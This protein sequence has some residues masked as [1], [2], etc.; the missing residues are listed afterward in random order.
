MKK[1]PKRVARHKNS[2]K[3]TAARTSIPVTPPAPGSRPDKDLYTRDRDQILRDIVTP[4]KPDA[5]RELDI[6]GPCET[7]AAALRGY[8]T[9]DYQHA[10]EIQNLRDQIVNYLTDGSRKRPFNIV[11][12]ADSGSG[13][14][15]FIDCLGKSLERRNVRSVTFN[16]ATLEGLDD[17]T[18]PMDAIRN[19]KVK[20]KLPLLFLDEFDSKESNY[21]ILLPLLWDGELRVAHRNLRLGKVVIILAGSGEKIAE[22]MSEARDMKARTRSWPNRLAD[23]LSRI[24]GPE[25]CIP[26]LDVNDASHDRRA[27]KACIAAS[28]LRKRFPRLEMAP[29][30]LLSFISRTRFRYGVRS[31]AYLIDTI[32]AASLE[33]DRLILERLGLPLA[34]WRRLAT[35][36]I[37]YHLIGHDGAVGIAESWNQLAKYTID[38]RLCARQTEGFLPE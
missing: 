38:V 24:N 5:Q 14:S 11:M 37:A 16:M 17:F 26:D 10:R 21:A 6:T 7:G 9:L 27:D 1:K 33:S 34:D 25:F 30:P 35:A 19:L 18:G 29:W 31:I 22:A 28:L 8:S 36:S 3:P 23:L 15:H 32:D 4:G 20:E 13:K 12:Q 2:D